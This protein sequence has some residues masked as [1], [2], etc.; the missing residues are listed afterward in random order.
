M[1][2]GGSPRPLPRWYD[3]AKLGVFVHWGLYSVPGWA[4]RSPDIQ[5]LLRD[6]GPRAMLRGNPYAEWYRNSMA[7]EG[8]PTWHH[9]RAVHGAGFGY[10]DFIPT[11]DA[12]SGAADLDGIA[13]LAA[14]AGAG[15]VVL[16]AKHADGFA[17][18]PSAV[19]H[20]RRGPYRARRDLVGGLTDA[21]RARGLRMGLYYCGGYDWAYSDAAMRRGADLLLAI[22]TTPEYER[23]AAAQIR[24]LVERYEPSVLWGD[25]AWPVGDLL[26]PLMAAYR[27]AVPDGVVNDRWAVIPGLEGRARRALLAAGGR[28]VEAVWSRLPDARRRLVFPPSPTG[29]F[30]TPEYEIPVAIRAD[31]WEATRGIGNSFGL[32]RNEDPGTCLTTEALVGM[33]CDVVARNGNLLIGVGPDEFGVVPEV[34]AAPLR[35]LGAWMR[36]N[37]GAIRGSR[38]WVDGPAPGADPTVRYTVVDGTVHA[39]IDARPDGEVVLRGLRDGS[40]D[41]ATLLATGGALVVGSADG[42]PSL[43]LPDPRPDEG[44]HAVRLG[45]HVARR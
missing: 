20:P 37:G 10:D 6:E 3:D 22:P 14:D 7:I 18:W 11:F 39:L 34:Q 4:P 15:Y 8:S 36:V 24:E 23:F 9:H 32:N 25:V 26:D 30:T 1:G 21:V 38:P 41:E 42:S 44:V 5:R 28:L 16:T 13:G 2:P 45:R 33:L 12:A 40:V 35:G 17:L 19:P 31:K 29:D 27:R 43:R